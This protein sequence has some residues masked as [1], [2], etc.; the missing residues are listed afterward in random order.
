MKKNVLLSLTALFLSMALTACGTQDTGASS[1]NIP[2]LDPSEP[3]V[4]EVWHYYNGPQKSAFDEL[5]ANFNETVGLEQG[6]VVEGYSQGNVTDLIN[7][8][9]DAA[10]KTV[11]AGEVPDIF[12]AYADTAYAVDQL[13][14]V[15]DLDPYLTEDE[16]AEYRPEFLEEG[17]ISEDGSLKIFPIAKSI[18]LFFLNTTDWAPFAADTGFDE[19]SFQTMEGVGKA[20]E[21]YYQWTDAL[22]PDVPEDGKALFGRDA[23]ANYCVIGSQQLGVELFSGYGENGVINADK[24]VFRTLWDAYYVPFING[25]FESY[26]RFRSDDAKIGKVISYV[27]SSS[28]SSYFPDQVSLNDLESYP[29]ECKVLPVPSFQ[30]GA[31][32]AVQQGAGM[33][34]TK[35]DEKTEYAATVFL[36]WFT[37]VDQNLSF[38][39]NS[40]YLPVKNAALDIE[41]INAVL[42]GMEDE[43][44]AG[45]MRQTFA[46]AIEQLSNNTLYTS[47]AFDG[48]T[49]ARAILDNALDD[50]AKADR[51]AVL[52]LMASGVSRADAVA[53]Y[54]TDANF[55]AWFEET[56]NQLKATLPNP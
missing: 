46:A 49:D 17:R 2:K 50:Q 5:V 18:E 44:T 55:D 51:Q 6:I 16:L 33:V 37:D 15:A 26:G 8:V 1:D 42:D 36:K 39:V 45:R 10:N 52:D 11:G 21:A 4:L 25:Y 32:Y 40:G 20:A 35:S 30:N 13:G 56:V 48:G 19:T 3:V 31:A 38:S 53:Q 34:V 43:A 29:I 41:K 22:T 23:M 24:E 54:N 28:G 7:N 9:I 47:R 14:L 27:G 12:A